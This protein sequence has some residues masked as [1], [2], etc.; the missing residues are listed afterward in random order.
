MQFLKHWLSFVETEF[1][2]QEKSA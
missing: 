2:E 1:L